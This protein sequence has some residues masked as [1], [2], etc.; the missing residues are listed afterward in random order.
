MS[1][2]SI[3]RF[4]SI[5][6]FLFSMYIFILFFFF[7]SSLIYS[8]FHSFKRTLS[9]PNSISFYIFLLIISCLSLFLCWLCLFWLLF[10][11]N[12]SDKIE[13]DTIRCRNHS[14]TLNISLINFLFFVLHSLLTFNSIQFNRFFSIRF[15]YFFFFYYVSVL[16][17]HC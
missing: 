14:H 17:R 4:W 11:F 15:M 13:V 8:L 9:H 12:Q 5:F 16:T 3:M 1:P 10:V 7:F 2:C 6:S